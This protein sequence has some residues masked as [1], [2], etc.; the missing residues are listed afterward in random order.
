MTDGG[1]ETRLRTRVNAPFTDEQ[2]VVDVSEDVFV[3][4]FAEDPLFLRESGVQTGVGH[5]VIDERFHGCQVLLFRR[6]HLKYCLRKRRREGMPHITGK[7][8]NEFWEELFAAG[9]L[10]QKYK[11]GSCSVVAI[12][13]PDSQI[14]V[15]VYFAS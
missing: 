12:L 8:Q 13:E 1:L 6:H 2:D 14:V 11:S 7:F 10:P 5:V 4:L 9:F 3:F 15:W